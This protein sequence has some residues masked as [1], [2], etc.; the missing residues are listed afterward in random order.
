MKISEVIHQYLEDRLKPN[1]ATVS[2][3][4]QLTRHFGHLS[5]TELTPEHIRQFIMT[6]RKAGASAATV[7][8]ELTILK[9]ICKRMV[10][11]GL[12]TLDPSQGIP[13]QKDVV[14]RD[15]WLTAEEEKAILRE[16]PGWLRK[17]IQFT[18]YT[19]MRRSEVLGLSAESLD[20]QRKVVVFRSAKARNG[21]QR[22]IPLVKKALEAIAHRPKS[23]PVF[24][25]DDGQPI[26]PDH[27]EYAFRLVCKKA[28]VRNIHLHDLRHTFAT[29]LVQRGQDL[30]TVQRLLGH[31]SPAMTQRYSHHSVESL[32]KA[33]ESALD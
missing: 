33:V 29:R 14:M 22:T 27:L 26:N 7:N 30:Y 10:Q 16:S 23:G 1:P 13:Y 8:R 2:N 19:G 25:K 18:L 28:G 6:R 21:E 12:V 3:C 24:T 15:R 20:L 5:P 31:R 17:V 4:N 9:Q 32:R 11:V